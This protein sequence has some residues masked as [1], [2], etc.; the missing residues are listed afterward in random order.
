[1]ETQ[2]EAKT[3]NILRR[4]LSEW[5]ILID[6]EKLRYPSILEKS[7]RELSIYVANHYSYSFCAQGNTYLNRDRLKRIQDCFKT[8]KKISIFNNIVDQEHRYRLLLSMLVSAKDNYNTTLN[9]LNL[10]VQLVLNQKNTCSEK[11]IQS[12][13]LISPDTESKNTENLISQLKEDMMDK[14]I[15]LKTKIK[16][17]LDYY[18]GNNI[19]LPLFKEMLQAIDYEIQ[20]PPFFSKNYIHPDLVQLFQLYPVDSFQW[21]FPSYEEAIIHENIYS[22]TIKYLKHNPNEQQ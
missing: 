1:M 18:D 8:K 5:K 22:R 15:D 9:T 3:S 12:G 6:K 20:K 16:A 21:A 10:M 7:A 19:E 2:Q 13:L 14:L 17:A 4:P 11:G